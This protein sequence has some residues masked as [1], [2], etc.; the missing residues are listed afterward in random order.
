MKDVRSQIDIKSSFVGN[1]KPTKN[2]VGR[3][4]KVVK[5]ATPPT[6]RLPKRTA[7]DVADKRMKTQNAT[8]RKLRS[9][10]K[11]KQTTAT[12]NASK[13]RLKGNDVLL[14]EPSSSDS[15]INYS[16][17]TSPPLSLPS[18]SS[19]L[20]SLNRD[21]E[22]IVRAMGFPPTASVEALGMY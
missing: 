18:S 22:P 16:H 13:A 1:E 8:T 15:Y 4:K 9:L 3:P 19:N 20:H 21:K 11:Q 7:R 6:T 2:K 10:A 17:E 12:I 5:I 14:K